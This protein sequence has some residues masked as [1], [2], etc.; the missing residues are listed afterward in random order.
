MPQATRPRRL[1]IKFALNLHLIIL[2]NFLFAGISSIVLLEPLCMKEIV[3]RV[4]GSARTA[5]RSALSPT[6]LRNKVGNYVELLSS[7]GKRDP[8]E[9]THLGIAY[10]HVVIEGPDPRYTGC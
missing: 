5:P 9:L 7:A 4:M 6:E 3:D 2:I 1:T 8:E 10:L